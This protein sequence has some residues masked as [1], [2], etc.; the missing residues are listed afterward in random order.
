MNTTFISQLELTPAFVYDEAKITS[1]RSHLKRIILKSGCQILFALKSFSFGPGLITIKRIVDGFG[2]SSLFEAKLARGIIGDSGSVHITTPGLRQD[3]IHDIIEVCDYITF[4]SLTQWEKYKESCLRKIKCGLRINPKISFVEDNRYNPSRKYSKLGVPIEKIVM[5]LNNG[6]D[7][8]NGITGLHF[9]NNCDSLDFGQ[10]LETVQSIENRLAGLL[11]QLEWINIGGGYIFDEAENLDALYEAIWLLR[12]KYSLDVYLEP[13]AA[14][15][16][17]AGYIVSS[18]LDIFEND[19]KNIAILDTSVNHMPEVFE[20]QY[21]PEILGS[22]E[23]GEYKYIFAGCTCLAG[24][25]F[26]E[27]NFKEP[28]EVGARVVFTDAGAYTLVKANMFNG[29]A[30]PTIYALTEKGVLIKK[31]QFTYG[32][33]ASRCGVETYEIA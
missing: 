18:V 30:L 5:S 14:I 13:G 33:F 23:T 8:L 20:Y 11:P 6:S 25:I 27:Y 31:R 32:D 26:G 1:L 19:G 22:I 29:I 17:K 12:S 10:L 16:R 7:I 28:L 3:E 4:N 21:Q 24:D 2:T 15:V 9:H